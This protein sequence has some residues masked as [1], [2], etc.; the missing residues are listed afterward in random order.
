MLGKKTKGVLESQIN[1]ENS[2]WPFFQIWFSFSTIGG[3]RGGNWI[4]FEL[5]FIVTSGKTCEKNEF[6]IQ[7]NGK[8]EFSKFIWLSKTLFVFFLAPKLTKN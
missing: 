2:P 8:R 5:L 3:E 4:K 6:E 7:K 1:L